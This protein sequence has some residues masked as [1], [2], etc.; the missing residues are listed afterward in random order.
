[1]EIAKITLHDD[2]KDLF[3]AEEERQQLF[4]SGYRII[5]KGETIGSFLL[6][7][8]GNGEVQLKRLVMEQSITPG[9]VLVIFEAIQDTFRKSQW[10]TLVVRSH[11][12]QLDE[13]LRYQQFSP[14]ETADNKEASLEKMWIYTG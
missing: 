2:V 5:E 11:S 9:H 8:L 13:L 10:S 14:N 1:M 6:T 3:I 12:E 7:P 4:D